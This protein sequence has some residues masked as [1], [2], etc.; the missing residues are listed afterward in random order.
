MVNE[1]SLFR[2]VDGVNDTPFPN[3]VDDEQIVINTFT[4][5]AQRMAATPT[6]TASI[7]YPRC[8]DNDWDINVYAT[9]NGEKYYIRQIP[10]SSKN[11]TS[12][13]YKHDITLYSE[14]FVLENIY[15][16]NVDQ[17]EDTSVYVR[18]NLMEFAEIINKSL[19]NSN[20]PY[21]VS[22]DS[23][24]Q[25]N[26]K[27]KETKD[28]TLEN[29]Y[30]SA[31]I[32]EIYNQWEIPFYFEGTNI[33]VKDCSENISD[34]TLEY[35]AD[36]SLL[37]I[38]KNNANFRKITRIS[39]YGSD[40]NIPFY[41]P[42]WSQKGIIEA[43]PLESNSILTNDMITITDMKKF[44]KK[45]PLN[46]N[47]KYFQKSETQ[48]IFSDTTLNKAGLK[49]QNQ[50]SIKHTFIM[51]F[52]S[53]RENN[54][55]VE[56]KFDIDIYELH[57]MQS[58]FNSPNGNA[59]L[60]PEKAYIFSP[61]VLSD[62]LCS[63]ISFNNSYLLPNFQKDRI[64]CTPTTNSY[65]KTYTWTKKEDENKR[66]YYALEI[67][68]TI[69]ISLVANSIP[70]GLYY[71]KICCEFT[72]SDSIKKRDIIALHKKIEYPAVI[73]M[74]DYIDIKLY[75]ISIVYPDNDAQEG[76]FLNE[77]KK[78]DL[79]DI[80]IS[81]N[82]TPDDSWNGEGFYQK[83]VS[84]IPTMPHLMPPLYRDSVGERKF[85]N[86]INYPY[87][88]ED[89]N[90]DVIGGEYIQ[91]GVHNDNYKDE[92]GNY[93]EF[94]TEWSE[95]NQNEHIQEF[96]GIYPNI[97]NV[98]NANND[99]IDEI[100]EVAFDDND[101]NDIDE[102]GN[103]IHPYFYVKIPI[104]NSDKG[105]NLFDHKIVGGN[106]QVAM[107]SGDCAA[108]TFEIMVKTRQS[109]D[110]N[111]SYEDV[112][113]PIMTYNYKPIGGDWEEKTSG[114]FGRYDVAQQDSSKNSIWLVLKKDNKTFNETYPNKDK[115]VLPKAGDKFVLL[116]IDMPKSYVLEAE[117]N[118][119][120][121]IIK[122]MFQNNVDKWN[123]QI[124]FSRIYLQE[125]TSFTERLSEN[126][127]LNVRYNN[128][129][130]NFYVNDYKYEVKAEEALPK[131]SVGLVDTISIHRGITQNV[132]DGVIK[133]INEA[134][135]IEENTIPLEDQ[136]LRKNV[137]ET[138][139]N[140]MTFEK[141]VEVKDALTTQKLKTPTI[142]SPLY[143]G[144]EVMGTGFELKEDE[145]GN[146]TLT[147]DNINVRKKLKATEFIIQQIQFQGGIVIQSAA[148]M[149]CNQVETLENGNFKCYF[150][151]K[152]GSVSN[153]FML[154]DLARCQRV[155][156]APKYY[157]R[158]VVEVGSN[159]I[160]LSNVT[161]EYENN[162]DTPSEGDIIVQMGNTTNTD[163]QSVIEM[164]T[165]GENSPSFIMYSG[166]NSFSLVGKDITG[167]VYHQK[168][169]DEN[170]N[171]IIEAYPELY[172]YGSMYFG[173]RNKQENFIQFAPNANGTF[174]ML[175]N[176]K[177]SFQ[178][179]TSDLGNALDSLLSGVQE[180]QSIA[181]SANS[182]A[183]QA[184]TTADTANS[185][186]NNANTKATQAQT[187]ANWKST[188]F[189][190]QPSNYDVGDLWILA[191][192]TTVNNISYK[193]GTILT[194]NQA[195]ATF[196]A[197]HWS[198]KVKY[199]DDTAIN[200]L[201]IGGVNL[202][203]N[204][205]SKWEQGSFSEN[206]A[207]GKDYA[208]VCK[209]QSTTRIRVKEPIGVKGNIY[210]K[211]HN[212]GYMAAFTQ[213][214][215]NKKYLGKETFVGGHNDAPHTLHNDT[216]YI[217]LILRKSDNTT[218]TPDEISKVKI[219]L[220]QGDKATSYK[221]ND[222]D[223][224]EA[225]ENILNG[226]ML[227]NFEIDTSSN[228]NNVKFRPNSNDDKNLTTP[229]KA[230]TE[231][232]FSIES[233]LLK[234]GSLTPT[235]IAIA[236]FDSSIS[237]TKKIWT[238]PYTDNK[239][240]YKLTTPST[241]LSTD[242]L[243]IYGGQNGS[244]K[245]VGFTA[246]GVKLA[247]GNKYIPW[248][249]TSAEQQALITL[250]N[251]MKG[252]T[253]IIGGLV[254]TNLIGMKDTSGEVQAGISG[255]SDNNRLRFWAGANWENVN[256][257]PFRVYDD[258]RVF[259]THFYGF[260]SAL[261]I[262]SQSILASYSKGSIVSGNNTIYII[263]IKKTGSKILLGNL[264][265]TIAISLPVVEYENTSI[266]LESDLEY[267]GSEIEIYNPFGLKLHI[268]G[269]NMPDPEYCNLYNM[270]TNYG[271]AR[272]STH[273][274]Y[275]ANNPIRWTMTRLTCS[276]ADV[277]SYKYAKF[278]CIRL[279]LSQTDYNTNIDGYTKL[280]NDGYYVILWVLVE[281]IK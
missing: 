68:R 150:D 81:I 276:I 101:N 241:I 7:E 243:L 38:K 136:F 213:F 178:G 113:N 21:R 59:V 188:T 60:I 169:F 2:Y 245:G 137:N 208:T 205:P 75:N 144:D 179:G 103:Y 135:N 251:A 79:S 221:P 139:P 246:F 74:G 125:N 163:R 61:S 220:E 64:Q 273:Y 37:S 148:A 185:T 138:M 112:L 259:G 67:K 14:R 44:D 239:L 129:T 27:T 166:I 182:K 51:P 212:S 263:D 265:N 238:I 155:G 197:S 70:K 26:E 257:A 201:E 99:P 145:N 130:Y 189:I 4:Y 174:E 109:E 147:V 24:V 105:F 95:S 253:D 36:E 97:T 111:E 119:R 274:G 100:L 252:S 69:N 40:K 104:T 88:N 62:L 154:D 132:V 10:S 157:W 19:E 175:I 124:D 223:I 106:M 249:G 142:K 131:I 275:P 49:Y 236:I 173:D 231:Y 272:P 96:S 244:T 261:P 133:A 146:S 194:A 190:A 226:A 255:L 218:I 18:C 264:G 80:G 162:S 278:K 151:T 127:K 219:Q 123:F 8:L 118:L 78:I 200:N 233:I 128:H 207:I 121:E 45:M 65:K 206:S 15:F 193:A 66:D 120:K 54:S 98:T 82:G 76:W 196:V 258:G 266:S 3:G 181:D 280:S 94:E 160:V 203:S 102:K 108:C 83:M 228:Y 34:V 260:H 115:G 224:I 42:N 216:R 39:G 279:N 20:L 195:S 143:G 33:I 183:T 117:E 52:E 250:N 110:N 55:I 171:V 270:T 48:P 199:T 35:G 30:L 152:E 114:H 89:F 170:G 202:I 57:K 165:V 248:E 176:A 192:G 31:A 13:M 164:N 277:I 187:T 22:V 87:A 230:N 254:M 167:I 222:A 16:V 134:F 6:I 247:E 47:V 149:E 225:K 156:Y 41:Y 29:V 32:Q 240:I 25:N 116:N 17:N 140:S 184:Q 122:Y 58:V 211:I 23:S 50:T 177:T 71:S 93:Y 234:N 46:G 11:N 141:D 12:V 191:S 1:L 9:F 126:C 235:N 92:N 56:I 172:S 214:D 256:S 229:L 242:V 237:T 232:V 217:C 227:I 267:V 90:V 198:E 268:C 72:T 91:L 209:Y 107:T 269:C 168:V 210:V 153:Q 28:I 215:E 85:Y 161:G 84:K 158:K 180:V 53:I 73:N 63:P 77:T 262:I 43:T 271:Q 186:A 159:F 281:C 5:N 86:A 204:I